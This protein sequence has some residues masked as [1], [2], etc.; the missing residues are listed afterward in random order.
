MSDCIGEAEIVLAGGCFWGMEK[1]YRSF[2]GISGVTAGYANGRSADMANYRDVCSGMTGFREAVKITYDPHI[3]S[4][5]TLLD[6]F[7]EATDP[8]MFNRQGM[9]TGSQYQTGIYWTESDDEAL[10]TE[11]AAEERKRF[12]EFYTELKPLSNFFP[13][14]EYHQ[15]Y[16]YKNPGG[17][18]HISD[19]KIE[20]F[21]DKYGAKG[22]A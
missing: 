12:R 4:L 1:L 18:C 19:A 15:R 3:I 14:E 5:K 21:V 22:T 20:R 16:L 17:Y 13:A 2:P 10:I 8:T 6:I 11:R 7:F 9:D